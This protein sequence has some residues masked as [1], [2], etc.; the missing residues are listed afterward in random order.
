MLLAAALALSLTAAAPVAAPV[1]ADRAY[2]LALMRML[3]HAFPDLTDDAGLPDTGRKL[4]DDVLASPAFVHETVGPFDVYVLLADELAGKTLAEKAL[5]QAVDGLVPLVPIMTLHFGR[6]TGLISGQRLPIV[7]CAADELRE[8]SA[9]DCLIAL[10]DHCESGPGSWTA[11]NGSLWSDALR[12]SMLVRTWDVQLVNLAHA[13]VRAQGPAFLEH[14]LGYL[15]LAHLVH[16]LLRQGSWGLVPPWLD[17]GLID[18]LDIEAYGQS[19]VGED[20]WESKT[21][22][23][24]REG[25]SGFLPTG[26]SPPPPVTGPPADLATTIRETGDAWARRSRSATRHWADLAADIDSKYPASMAFMA[27]HGS[28]LPRDRAYARCALHLMLVVAPPDGPSL[29]EALDQSAVT[30]PGGMYAAEPLTSLIS[31]RLRGVPEVERLAALPLG[32]KLQE[33]GHPEIAERLQAL[34]AEA[35]LAL[36]DH[37]EQGNWLYGQLDLEMAA[38]GELFQ[39]FLEAEYYEQMQAWKPIGAALD[40]GVRAALKASPTFP[41]TLAQRQAVAKDFRAALPH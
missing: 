27:E 32:E 22:G 18:E 23:W 21:E 7:L 1:S 15:T 29:L 8:I 11:S 33:L 20:K 30:L 36:A 10:L 3:E 31:A 5:K 40:A 19:W 39:L 12:Q 37:R 13:D 17:Q 34:G 9:F 41:D 25:W 35:A 24:F 26:T 2:D 14:E 4:L 6:T 16:G 28:F 38:R